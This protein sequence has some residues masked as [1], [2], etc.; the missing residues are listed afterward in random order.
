M[1]WDKEGNQF[2]KLPS[3][4]ELDS[5]LSKTVMELLEELDTVDS[6]KKKLLVREDQ[7]KDE[8][9]KLQR[10]S[11][12]AGFRHGW[13]CFMAQETAGRKTLDI[14]ALMEAGVPAATINTCYKQGKPS[15]RIT[16]KHLDEEV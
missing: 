4:A 15:V 8:L 2:A 5:K 1:P 14:M 3:V 7:L 6:E 12:K 10:E 11:G 13:L 16:F 9:E